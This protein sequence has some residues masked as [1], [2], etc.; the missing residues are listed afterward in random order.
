[1]FPANLHLIR[2]ATAH[3][4]KAL[5]D[6][7]AASGAPPLT[8]RILVGEVRGAVAAAVSRDNRRTI[9]DPELRAVLTSLAHGLSF[10]TGAPRLPE[11]SET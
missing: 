9:A 4:W 10:T 8:G 3:D 2:A 5:R 6:L 7:A 1:M 11:P